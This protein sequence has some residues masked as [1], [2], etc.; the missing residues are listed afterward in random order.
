MSSPPFVSDHSGRVLDGLRRLLCVE[1]LRNGIASTGAE[2]R[3]VPP[4]GSRAYAVRPAR[5]LAGRVSSRPLLADRRL[6]VP[7][8]IF[9]TDPV[10]GRERMLSVFYGLGLSSDQREQAAHG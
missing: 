10:R 6:I 1:S 2:I 3:I 7:S 8:E 5:C 9:A 4:L